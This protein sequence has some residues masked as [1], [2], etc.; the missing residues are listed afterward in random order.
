MPI[1]LTFKRG[2]ADLYAY[3][4]ASQFCDRGTAE[5]SLEKVEHDQGPRARQKSHGHAKCL[6]MALLYNSSLNCH[7]EVLQHY[8]YAYEATRMY[9]KLKYC[10]FC[11]G[12][13][14]VCLP[15]AFAHSCSLYSIVSINLS[16]SS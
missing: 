7:F 1:W 15:S 16:I 10:Y 14:F 9:I 6:G 11:G 12:Y 2:L 8:N 4:L 13:Y 3:Q 5:R